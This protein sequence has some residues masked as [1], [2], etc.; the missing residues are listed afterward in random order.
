VFGSSGAD[1]VKTAAVVVPSSRLTVPATA[2]VPRTSRIEV[3]FNVRASTGSLK[4][5]TMPALSGT[6]VSFFGGSVR[7]TFGGRRAG[8][9][10]ERRSGLALPA[11]WTSIVRTSPARASTGTGSKPPFTTAVTTALPLRG[12]RTVATL[13]PGT[14]R[15]GSEM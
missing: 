10:R 14:A 4:T 15:G 3:P 2:L 9:A 13:P 1:G 11:T 6:S 5:T 12:F 7:T 8:T